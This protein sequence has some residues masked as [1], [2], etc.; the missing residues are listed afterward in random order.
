MSEVT[1]LFGRPWG[2]QRAED[3][4][5]LDALAAEELGIEAYAIP[6]DPVVNGDPERAL[7]RLPRADGRRWLYRGWMLDE[8]EYTSLHEAIADRGEEMVV[9]PESFA[10]T[11]YVPN[12]LS[13]LG[14]RTAPARWTEGE[15]IREAWELAAELGP[16]PWIVKDHV[17]SAK[18]L[19]HRACFVP[20]GATYE[21]FAEVCEQLLSARGDRFERGFVVKKFLDLA[22]LPGWTPEQR[23]VTDEHRLVFWEGRLVASAPY[24]DVDSRLSDPGQFAYLGRIVDSP[25]FTADVARL[26]SG[27]HTVIELND[28]GSS[29]FPEQLDPRD[30]YRAVAG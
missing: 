1:I 29:I 17:K 8:D 6:L 10:L 25:F 22:T 3:R 12:Y 15:D 14:D 9:D 16:P 23:R 24:Y 30:L 4:F 19:W 27:G 5:E 2:D 28:G 7:R 26:A 20:E 13:L 18:E 11:T 21:D